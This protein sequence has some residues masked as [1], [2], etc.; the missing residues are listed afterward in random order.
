MWP[1]SRP[2]SRCPL[3]ER[4]IPAQTA[5]VAD[6]SPPIV[7]LYRRIMT[8]NGL[9]RPLAPARDRA[10]ATWNI[11]GGQIVPAPFAPL[12]TQTQAALPLRPPT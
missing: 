7:G 9:F 3:A 2:A 8:V 6:G 4:R 12:G 11:T 10:V 1:R 5:G